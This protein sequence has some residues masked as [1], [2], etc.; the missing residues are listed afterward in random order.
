[1]KKFLF[2]SHGVVFLLG[3]ALGLSLA[4]SLYFDPAHSGEPKYRLGAVASYGV[5]PSGEVP[6]RSRPQHVIACIGSAKDCGEPHR[7]PAPGTAA[8]ILIGLAGLA[9]RPRHAD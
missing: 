3:V 9:W 6:Y 7:I 5:L 4:L 1:M 8:L 2:C